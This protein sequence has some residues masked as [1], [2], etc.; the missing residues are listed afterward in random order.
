MKQTN[1]ALKYLL[2]QYRAIF[3][4]AYFKGLVSAAVLTAGLAGVAQP[5]TATT[6][7]SAN[8]PTNGE[9]ITVDGKTNTNIFEEVTTSNTNLKGELVI[10]SGSVGGSPADGNLLLGASGSNLELSGNDFSITIDAQNADANTVGLGLGV[11]GNA[12]TNNFTVD[13][14]ELNIKKHGH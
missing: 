7:T 10:H 2:A 14:N 4:N 5:A 11:Q 12:T 1:N 6:L 9:P 3:K 13:V 8:L